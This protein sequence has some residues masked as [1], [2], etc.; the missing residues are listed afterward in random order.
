MRIP[1][2]GR[3]N[4][5]WF[6]PQPPE[7]LGIFR[8]M[9]AVYSIIYWL[10][11]LPHVTLLFSTQ[12]INHPAYSL[13]A[14]F[15]AGLRD[16][17]TLISQPVPSLWAWVLYLSIFVCLGFV[18]VGLWTR[19]ALALYFLLY[20]H[21]YFLQMYQLNGS[22]DQLNLLIILLTLIS[23]C[24]EAFSLRAVLRRRRGQAAP[25]FVSYWAARLI[26]VQVMLMYLGTGIDKITS[27]NWTDGEVLA[28]NLAGEWGTPAA[29]WLLRHVESWAFYDV[30]ALGTIVFELYAPVGLFWER[31][32]KYYFAAGL[33]FHAFIGVM[34][35]VWGFFIMPTAYVLFVD[36]V[37]VRDWCR[38][39]MYSVGEAANTR[40]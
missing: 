18:L 36:P 1:V 6:T 38:R 25:A 23:P 27:G 3:W 39:R 35:N 32:Q 10:D 26:S 30:A 28:R 4:A 12:G 17:I 9:L 21:H 16:W 15:P 5:F 34:M 2:V 7:A 24:S 8:I 13:P 19:V 40:A 22:Y 31:M 37:R 29:F 20:V 11:R 33:M 14:G